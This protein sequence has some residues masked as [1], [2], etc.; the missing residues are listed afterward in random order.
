MLPTL[1]VYRSLLFGWCWRCKDHKRL[2]GMLYYR[3]DAE[4]RL[5]AHIREEH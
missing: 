3:R 5:I 2:G 1:G 4:A